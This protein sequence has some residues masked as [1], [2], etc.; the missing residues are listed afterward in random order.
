MYLRILYIKATVSCVFDCISDPF[1]TRKRNKQRK[2]EI[3]SINTD[4]TYLLTFW[5][6]TKKSYRDLR[7]PKKWLIV[8]YLR[9]NLLTNVFQKILNLHSNYHTVQ[10]RY[11]TILPGIYDYFQSIINLFNSL[12]CTYIYVCTVLQYICLRS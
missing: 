7:L 2:S 10:V 12:I 11:P 3:K 8:S 5:V 4:I 6:F 1:G 9:I